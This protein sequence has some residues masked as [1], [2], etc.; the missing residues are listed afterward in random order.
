MGIKGWGLRVC[1]GKGKLF[2]FFLYEV[3]LFEK[4]FHTE[5]SNKC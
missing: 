5:K 1:Q 2:F 4:L 3:F